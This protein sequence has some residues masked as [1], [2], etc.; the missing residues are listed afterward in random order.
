MKLAQSRLRQYPHCSPNTSKSFLNA[1]HHHVHCRSSSIFWTG[2]FCRANLEPLLVSQFRATF[3]PMA[4]TFFFLWKCVRRCKIKP[5][6]CASAKKNGRRNSK[7]G[8]ANL[9]LSLFC[10]KC[11]EYSTLVIRE[12]I[13]GGLTSPFFMRLQSLLC[14]PRSNQLFRLKPSI[15]HKTVG[16]G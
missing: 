8:H 6:H 5:Q 9:S 10:S 1:A 16:S 15:M 3:S 7:D 4:A 14:Q 2:N 11:R 13:C 12:H